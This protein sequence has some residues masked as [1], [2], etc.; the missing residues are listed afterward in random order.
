MTREGE[1]A[2]VKL[3]GEKIGYGNLM[4]IASALWRRDLRENGIPE[5]GAFYPVCPDFVD[6]EVAKEI[7]MEQDITAQDIELDKLIDEG[8]I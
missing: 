8:K 6:K 3:V 5:S 1:Y 4:S 7:R 2:A